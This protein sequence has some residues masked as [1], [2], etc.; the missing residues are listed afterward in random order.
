MTKIQRMKA[1]KLRSQFQSE[2]IRY[3]RCT[4]FKFIYTHMKSGEFNHV[5]HEQLNTGSFLYGWIHLTNMSKTLPF[6]PS[7]RHHHLLS[8]VCFLRFPKRVVYDIFVH[9]HI[10]W[11]LFLYEICLFQ[12]RYLYPLPLKQKCP[13][14][15]LPLSIPFIHYH[16]QF[17]FMRL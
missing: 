8:V 12:F 14:G 1:N 7:P 16:Y 2:Y 17:N 15:V 9:T 11:Y 6:T 3:F 5:S 10:I 13:F 4:V